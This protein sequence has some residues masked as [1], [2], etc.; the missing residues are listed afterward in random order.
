MHDLINVVIQSPR[1][2]DS[3]SFEKTTKVSEVIE[4]ARSKFGFE[5]GVFI[6]RREKTGE[7]LAPER[8]LVSFHLEDGEI[9][10][11]IPEMGS[12]V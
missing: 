12:G 10:L 11:L 7:T 9:L 5:P 6:L 8:P 1:G 2:R 4:K 3:F